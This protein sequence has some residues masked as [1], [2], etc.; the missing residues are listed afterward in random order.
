MTYWTVT[1]EQK[2]SVEEHELWQKDDMV[3]RRITGFRWGKFCVTTE[4]DEPPELDQFDGPGGDAVNMH[5]CG[6]DTEMESMD[7]GWYGDVIWPDAMSQEEQDLLEE[8]WE[9]EYYDGWEG[10]GWS[11][12]ETEVWFSGPLEII[13]V[14]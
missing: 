6:Y 10:Q 1:T 2:K 4:D 8:L 9:E 13:K 3:I 14:E 5:D 12:Y 7:D 11:Q